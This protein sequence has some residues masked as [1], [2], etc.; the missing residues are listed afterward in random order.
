MPYCTAV[1][2]DLSKNIK[3]A[4]L[5]DKNAQFEVGESCRSGVGIPQNYKQAY[6]WFSLAAAQGH[7]EAKERQK[8]LEKKLTP[9]QLGEAQ[10]LA[11]YTQLAISEKNNLPP[12][13]AEESIDG[14]FILSETEGDLFIV[15]GILK[16]PAAHDISH[17]KLKGVLF[18]SDNIE[19]INRTVY[20]GNTIDEANLKKMKIT[21]I[22]KQLM[23]E[24]RSIKPDVSSPFM[25]VFS[26]LPDNLK[27]FKVSLVDFKKESDKGLSKIDKDTE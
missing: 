21:E 25:F 11:L 8:E 2:N 16:N 13:I 15:T 24:N 12:V 20:C 10:D 9:E 18:T 19:A 5:G 4:Q 3:N 1:A 22:E 26:N 7:E 27:N 6:M 23:T 14:K 17:V